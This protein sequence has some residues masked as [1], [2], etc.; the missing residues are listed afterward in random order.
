MADNAPDLAISTEKLCFIIAK[1]TEFDAKDV[2]TDPDSA[3]NATDDGM[4]SVLEAH[5]DDPVV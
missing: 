3:S 4:I 5:R 1:A 2:V